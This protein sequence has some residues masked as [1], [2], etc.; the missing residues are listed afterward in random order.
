MNGISAFIKVTFPQCDDT[1][2][3][4]VSEPESGLFAES[5]SADTLIL[6]FLASRTVRNIFPAY[7]ILL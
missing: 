2:R 3:V 4:I 6:E 1:V 5:E 7:D